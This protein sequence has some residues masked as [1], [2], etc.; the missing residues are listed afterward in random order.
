MFTTGFKYYFG[1]GLFLLLAAV[2]YG[3]TSGGVDFG[4]FPGQMGSLYF[5]M[6]GALTMGYKGAVGDHFG[7]AVLLGGA[8]C[9]FVAGGMIVAFR[10]ADAKSLAEVAGT[11]DAPALRPAGTSNYWAPLGAFGVGVIAVGLASSGWLVI[12]GVAVLAFVAL[13][14]TMQAWA[15]RSTGD[16]R[17]N[18]QLR[19]RIMNPIEVPVVG[20]IVAGFV[21]IGISR[22]Y[23]AIPKLGA[24][25]LSL[26][27]AAAIFLVAIVVAMAPKV[28]KNVLT[29]LVVLGGVAVLASGIAGVATG[30]REL[31]DES[32]EFTVTGS[33]PADDAPIG[34]TF[35]GTPTTAAPA[36]SHSEGDGKETKS[37]EGEKNEGGE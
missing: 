26:G 6:L 12:A 34:P 36:E 33:G 4:M 21:A 5:A 17:L 7:Y 18:A 22:L 2:L 1:F 23:L 31:H 15:D 32:E 37:G 35:R 30:T 9:A 20:V 3:W 10:D 16:H 27:I 11:A 25:W 13:E 19:S 14:W 24:T 8:A 29:A 28:S